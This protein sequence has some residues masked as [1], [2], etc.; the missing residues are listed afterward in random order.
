MFSMFKAAVIPVFGGREQQVLGFQEAMKNFENSMLASCNDMAVQRRVEPS[1]EAP[2]SNPLVTPIN[3]GKRKAPSTPAQVVANP[4]HTPSV[5]VLTTPLQNT[6]DRH[7]EQPETPKEVQC[8]SGRAHKGADNNSYSVYTRLLC[9]QD[10]F[11]GVGVR[12]IMNKY[13]VKSERSIRRWLVEWGKDV[14]DDA[15]TW[16]VEK[17]KSTFRMKG[18]GRKLEDSDLEQHLLRFM[19]EL[20]EDRLQVLNPLLVLEAIFQRPNFKGGPESPGWRG[21]VANFLQSF[22]ARNNFVWRCPTTIGQKLPQGWMGKWYALYSVLLQGGRKS[23]KMCE[24]ANI[25]AENRTT[26]SECRTICANR[27]GG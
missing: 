19:Q 18:A 11:A 15:V 23:H 5:G 6:E 7:V 22:Q 26:I 16:T 13:A 21:K 27:G 20:H 24:H 4:T 2:P 8:G 1:P 9:I 25:W 3:K 17:Q 12:N 14:Y 10:F